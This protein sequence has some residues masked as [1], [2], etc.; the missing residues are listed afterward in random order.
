MQPTKTLPATRNDPVAGALW[1]LVS[2][3]LLAGVAAL[4][5]YLTSIDVH[6]FQVVFLRVLFAFVTM[7]PLLVFR[8]MDLCRTDQ[9]KI[10]IWRVVSAT[11]AMT[12]WFSALA[13]LPVGEVTAI[14][15]LTP[16]FATIGAAL[17]LSEVVR[18][19][20]W[21]ATL[22]GFI[23]VLI[24]LRPGFEGLGAGALL[25]IV[26]AFAMGTTSVILKHMTAKDD[27]DKIVFIS[28]TLL[29]P[30]TSVA[31]MFVWEAL[32]VQQWLLLFVMGLIATLGHM[33][34]VRAFAATEASLVIGFDF[35]RLPFAVLYGYLAL[36]ELID[37][38]T[39]VGAGVIFMST[40]YIARREAQLK[41]EAAVAGV[42]V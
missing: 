23:G 8:G 15:F 6:P 40:V 24:I 35:A 14:S 25:A 37:I 9:P 7:L 30:L 18:I 20:R 12:T 38:W 10:Y 19:R 4:G 11:I 39:W 28:T 32:T 33:T 13:L 1:M 36:G 27:P 16:I 2:C 21:I 26:S 17:F 42:G 31:A 5:R 34:L 41:R 22:V 29:V 3:A